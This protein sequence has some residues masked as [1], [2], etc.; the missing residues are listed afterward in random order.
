MVVQITSMHDVYCG[1]RGFRKDVYYLLDERCTRMKF[2]RRSAQQLS[3]T[4]YD[5]DAL[6]GY[7]RSGEQR[8]ESRN[9][10]S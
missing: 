1:L 6:E 8:M 4:C 3:T 2:G 7:L 10:L 9:S 5:R